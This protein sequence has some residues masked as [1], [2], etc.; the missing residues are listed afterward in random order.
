MKY[1]VNFF[2]PRL[3]KACVHWTDGRCKGK[4]ITGVEFRSDEGSQFEYFCP[5]HLKETKKLMGIK[6]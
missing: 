1:E 6:E 2:V 3:K 5:F 4:K